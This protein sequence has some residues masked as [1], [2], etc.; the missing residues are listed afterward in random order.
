M[1]L[2]ALGRWFKE[3]ET[4][5]PLRAKYR[6]SQILLQYAYKKAKII[7]QLS[8]FWVFAS[9]PGRFIEDYRKIAKRLN[10]EGY[11]NPKIDIMQRVKE[12][13]QESD[14]GEWMMIIDNADD[15]QMFFG[16]D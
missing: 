10:L 2:E 12:E 1:G 13:L 3:N 14:H 16:I 6:K 7:P 11:D 9:N 8:I 15:M 4:S 5:I